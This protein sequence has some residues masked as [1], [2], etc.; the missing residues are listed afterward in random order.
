[1][2]R[3]TAGVFKWKIVQ[4]KPELDT[5][6]YVELLTEEE[7][8]E[9]ERYAILLGCSCAFVVCMCVCVYIYMCVCVCVCVCMC[10]IVFHT[11]LCV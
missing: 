2:D 8:L 10:V 4:L 3:F 6:I 5:A 9:L 11:L 1:V 7:R